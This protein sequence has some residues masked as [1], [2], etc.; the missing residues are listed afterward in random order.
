MNIDSQKQ[1]FLS[2]CRA[3]IHREGIENLLAWLESTDFFT[4]PASANYHGNYAGGLCEHCL[5]VLA[6]ARRAMPLTNREFSEESLV[7]TTLF[8]DLCKVDFYKPDA[9]GKSY[10]AD[11]TFKFGGHGSKSVFLIERFLHLTD[12][13]AVAV[14]CHM[15]CFEIDNVGACYTQYPLA[16]LVHVADEAATYL[17]GR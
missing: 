6:Y 9:K 4:A 12:E 15:G 10:H 14:N 11:E 16:W 1:E 2:V 3:S 8:H 17:L 13:E 5:D 7:I